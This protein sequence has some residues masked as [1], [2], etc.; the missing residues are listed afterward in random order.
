VLMSMLIPFMSMLHSKPQWTCTDY[1]LCTDG[2]E[3][4]TMYGKCMEKNMLL[5]LGSGMCPGGS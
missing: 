3:N 5:W 2:M 4:S 1:G